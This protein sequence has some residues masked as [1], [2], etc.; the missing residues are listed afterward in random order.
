MSELPL[1]NLSGTKSLS[2]H[3]VDTLSDISDWEQWKATIERQM[4]DLTKRV[5][6]LEPKSR[7]SFLRKRIS[8]FTIAKEDG[9]CG[10]C[11]CVRLVRTRKAAFLQCLWLILFIAGVAIIGSTDFLRAK[12]N[13]EAVYKPEKKL[14]TVNYL[15]SREDERY[16]IPYIYL[17]FWLWNKDIKKGETWIRSEVLNDT[18]EKLLQSQNYFRETYIRYIDSEQRINENPPLDDVK[19]FCMEG[20]ISAHKCFGY[21]RIK[22][23]NPNIT[24][25]YFEVHLPLN[26]QDLTLNSTVGVYG[27]WVYVGTQITT[28][29]WGDWV[30]VSTDIAAWNGYPHWS[31]IDYQEQVVHRWN[32]EVTRLFSSSL[33][34]FAPTFPGS[35][36]G[37]CIDFTFRSSLMVEHWAEYVEYDYFDW[38]SAMGGIISI[39]SVLFFWGAYYI[40]II[41]GEKNVMGILP[42]ISFIFDNFERIHLAT[43]VDI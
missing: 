3:P 7:K 32:N 1:A 36:K 5:A 29:N 6:E 39:S 19:A 41:C 14:K 43:E 40:A 18:L 12:Q 15:E 25:T 9:Y 38:C 8:A 20:S 42:L 23:S 13:L 22:P 2:G 27:M 11:T 16:E 21:F 30:F 10:L 17:Y 24:H 26:M 28:P 35:W 4:R 37:C 33:E 31:I 34:W